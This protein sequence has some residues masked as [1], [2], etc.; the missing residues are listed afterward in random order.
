MSVFGREFSS[1]GF[2]GLNAIGFVL[3]ALAIYASKAKSPDEEN[4]SVT[5]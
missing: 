4:N 3:M 5:D 2:S 1:I